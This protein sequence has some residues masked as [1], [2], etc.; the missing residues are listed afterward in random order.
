MAA[1]RTDELAPDERGVAALRVIPIVLLAGLVALGVPLAM[2]VSAH[3]DRDSR[4]AAVLEAARAE[5]TNLMNISYA[6]AGR[7]LGRII[8][9]ST[10]NLRRQFEVQRAHADA[11]AQD[12]STLTG[13][14]VSTG[15]L[16][17]HEQQGLARVVVA[18]TG[19]DSSS[20]A[21][22]TSRHY[23]W[24]LTLRQV[25]GHWLVTDAALEGVPS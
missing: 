9:G 22:A 20:G 19:S 12:R 3:H 21:A 11:L 15:L 23:R 8:A 14:V 13:Q 6:S 7:D 5:V 16:W 4:R 10:G 24:V 1:L 2:Q 18:A 17:L 25:G